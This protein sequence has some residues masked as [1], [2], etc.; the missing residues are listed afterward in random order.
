MSRTR[1]HVSWSIALV[2]MLIAVSERR[3]RAYVDPGSAS[4]FFQLLVGGF[5]AAAYVTRAYWAR[6][7]HFVRGRMLRARHVDE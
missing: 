1:R 6:V 5:F 4:Y 7:K 2:L 3:A